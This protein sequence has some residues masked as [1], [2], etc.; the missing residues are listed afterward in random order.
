[1][2]FDGDGDANTA[3]NCVWAANPTQQDSSQPADGIG[4][5]CTCGDTDEDGGVDLLDW[6]VLA[7]ALAA[8]G[9]GV[10]DPTKCSVVGGSMDCDAQDAARVRASLAGLAAL[11]PVCR[12]LVGAG[13]LPVQMSVAGDSIT[14]AFAASCECNLGFGCLLECLLGGTEQPQYSWFDGSSSAV[15]TLLDRYV[16]FDPSIGA[17]SSAP[18]SGARMRGGSDSFDVQ[19]LRILGQIPL[20]DL[21]VVL[22][23]GNDI[24]SR[25]CAQPGACGSPL[26]TDAEWREAVDLGLSRL[27]AGLPEGATVY[28]GSV[29]R[30][31]DLYASGLVK[32]TEEEDVDCEFAWETFDICRIVTNASTTNGETQA[33]RLAAIEERQRRYNEI[34]REEAAAYDTNANGLNPRGIRVAAEYTDEDTPSVGTFFFTADDINGSDCFHPSLLG[35]NAIANLLWRNSPVR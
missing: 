34:L 11:E 33:F 35:Q 21:A 20:P 9:P 12:A 14:R 16:V 13:E 17:D 25:D 19:A 26:F 22:L 23:G 8:L 3:D 15:F 4:D 27:T 30:V 7:R 28:L 18:D 6:V 10:G 32:Q 29:P 5:A 24:C 31:Q 1:V 2:D